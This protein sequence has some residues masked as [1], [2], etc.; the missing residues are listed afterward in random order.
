MR[1][2]L[3]KLTGLRAMVASALLFSVM[4]A[5]IKAVARTIPSVEVVVI[6]NLVHA[7][8]FVPLWWATTDRSLGNK[9]LLVARGVLLRPLGDV[10]VLMPPLT[11]TTDELDRILDALVGALDDLVALDGTSEASP[12]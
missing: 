3:A 2:H 1:R 8:I 5:L 6:R 7:A 9:K 12:R 10:V 11:T 4:A